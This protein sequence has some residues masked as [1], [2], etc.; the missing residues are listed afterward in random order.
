MMESVLIVLI[1]CICL[2]LVSIFYGISKEQARKY[3][4]DLLT[5]E[6]IDKIISDNSNISDDEWHTWLQNRHN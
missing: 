3:K 5:G 4:N 1:L 6:K 2:V